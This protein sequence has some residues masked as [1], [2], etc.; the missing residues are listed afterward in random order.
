[1][2]SRAETK[3]NNIMEISIATRGV[4]IHEGKLL[5]VKHKA[6]RSFWC[7]PGG[8]MEAGETLEKAME[9]ELIEETG[10]RP[11]VGKLLFIQQ[12]IEVDRPGLGFFFYIKN[13]KD[14][15]EFN[16]EK[17]SHGFEI[18]EFKFV[19]PDDPDYTILPTYLK[20]E[21]K[22]LIEVGV[23]NFEIQSQV[24]KRE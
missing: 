12:F 4:I 5:V 16:K 21:V 2:K 18:Y 19:V 1:M 9:R 6:D 8:R 7:L 20:N 11:E 17:A 15:V 22:R 3:Y 13:A 24:T 23:D 14:Y 10:V